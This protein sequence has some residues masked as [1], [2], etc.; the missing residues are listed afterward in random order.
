MENFRQNRD[1]RNNPDSYYKTYN[2][3]CVNKGKDIL[4]SF[5]PEFNNNC[6]F[7]YK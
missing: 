2:R 7:A 5:P 6:Q 4:A 3:E 1:P